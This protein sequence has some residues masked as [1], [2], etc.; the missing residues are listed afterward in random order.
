VGDGD[1]SAADAER[2]RTAGE[3][4]GG[5]APALAA[6]IARP[7]A[8]LRPFVGRWQQLTGPAAA[9]GVE[10]TALYVDAAF[11]A[12]NE[13]GLAPDW[14]FT[15]AAELHARL[16]ER[17]CGHPLNA[18]STH[19]TKRSEDVRMRITALSELAEEWEA[20]FARWHAR[21]APLRP[22]PDTAPDPNEEW[23]LYQTLVGAWPIGIERVRQFVQKAL[24]EAKVHTSWAG[25]DEAYEADVNAFAEA[26]LRSPEFTDDLGALA[27]RCAAIGARN[28]LGLLVLKL[29]A[30]GVPDVYWGNEDWDLSLVDPDNRRP[31]DFAGRAE[32]ADGASD[33]VA[34]TRAG[35]RLRRRD[36][37][38]FAHGAYV[39]LATAGRHADR[40]I[41]FARVHE[42]RWALAAVSRLTEGVG[43]WG[44]TR[45]VLPDAAPV[46]EIPAADLFADLP[47]ALLTP[48]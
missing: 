26:I 25:P 38:L 9:K 41:A 16:A 6:A 30:P 31:V 46:A 48:E 42:G 45:V 17:A 28:S 24:R 15:D 34:L 5:G 4:A 11:L 18:T 8:G 21:N 35:L 13:P 39:P 10:D 23:L 12:R 47:A 14:P 36:P 27:D 7:A 40:V 19:D 43:D 1:A 20:A 32:R 22:R 2:L 33:K 3:R 29:A 37:D 44:D